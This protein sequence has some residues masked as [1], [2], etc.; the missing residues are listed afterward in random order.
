VAGVEQAAQV[1][2]VAGLRAEDRVA[3]SMRRV[4]GSSG[5]MPMDRYTA[6]GLAFVVMRGRW[7]SA[8]TR[9]SSRDLPH[10][11]SGARM[12]SRGAQCQA[13]SAWVAA[14]HST[15]AVVASGFGR[16]T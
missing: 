8:S 15:T 13:G 16:T 7:D 6:D 11:F 12:T 1:L 9:S 3:S 4:G 2:V 14:I 10:R 5:L